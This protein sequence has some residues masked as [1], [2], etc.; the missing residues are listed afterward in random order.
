MTYLTFGMQ[1]NDVDFTC[2]QNRSNQNQ[3]V[4]FSSQCYRFIIIYTFHF[5]W[6]L[7]FLDS[8]VNAMAEMVGNII[9]QGMDN[10]IQSKK[11]PIKSRNKFWFNQ[12]CKLAVRSSDPERKHSEIGAIING[13]ILIR[14][15]NR[16]DLRVPQYLGAKRLYTKSAYV[17]K[18]FSAEK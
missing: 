5:N 16:R 14:Y 12:T 9:K 18:F 10:F 8:N 4:I 13:N 17:L 15:T 11:L 3:F 2:G 6:K 7:C 1:L